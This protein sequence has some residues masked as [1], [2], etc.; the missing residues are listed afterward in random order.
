MK[1]IFSAY[2]LCRLKGH[3]APRHVRFIGHGKNVHEA[4]QDYTYSVIGFMQMHP[5][6]D[7]YFDNRI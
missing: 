6:A 1:Y 2:M 3:K 5:D 4:L 7:L